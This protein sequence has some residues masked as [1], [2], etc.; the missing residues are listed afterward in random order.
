MVDRV[1]EY[2]VLDPVVFW[3][4]LHGTSTTIQLAIL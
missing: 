4:K 2:G 3:D 1:P